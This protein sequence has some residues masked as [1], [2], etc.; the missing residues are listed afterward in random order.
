MVVKW[1]GKIPAGTHTGE[2]MTM[3]LRS[4]GT[5]DC[6]VREVFPGVPAQPEKHVA[7]GWRSQ[8]DDQLA[9]DEPLSHMATFKDVPPR[10]ESGSFTPRQ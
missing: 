5:E 1:K 7:G 3:D 6:R 9:G 2:F 8:Q 10:Q 4:S